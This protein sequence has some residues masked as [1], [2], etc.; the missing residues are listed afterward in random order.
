MLASLTSL[1]LASVDF[2]PGRSIQDAFVSSSR[3]R[4]YLLLF[5]MTADVARKKADDVGALGRW[6][7]WKQQ[8]H[9]ACIKRRPYLLLH[10]LDLVLLLRT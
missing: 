9:T 2:P 4:T 5:Y 10:N 7:S 3:Q 8:L 1:V 6:G